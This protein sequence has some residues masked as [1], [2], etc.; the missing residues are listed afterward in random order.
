MCEFTVKTVPDDDM[1][2][3]HRLEDGDIDCQFFIFCNYWETTQSF[4]RN[5][6]GSSAFIPQP[7]AASEAQTHNSQTAKEP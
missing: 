4:P 5:Q 2:K 6:C 3:C 1:L 7:L